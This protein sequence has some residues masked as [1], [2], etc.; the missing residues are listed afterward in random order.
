MTFRQIQIST[1]LVHSSHLQFVTY[2]HLYILINAVAIVAN[3]N[4]F[5][6]M[7][8]RDKR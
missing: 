1:Y 7:S 2:V 6:Y 5:V 3:N 4:C 8:I